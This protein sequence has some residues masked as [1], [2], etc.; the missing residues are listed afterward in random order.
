ML[1]VSSTTIVTGSAPER[2]IGFP[3]TGSTL[4]AVL[5]FK[6]SRGEAPARL[7][8]S[9]DARCL[10]PTTDKRIP[11]WRRS[12]AIRRK[13]PRQGV[14]RMWLQDGGE[15]APVMQCITISH[16]FCA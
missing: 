7:L 16:G 12:S 1:C 13:E 14:G 3:G 6:R 8:V 4:A 11:G 15:G 5:P 9:F 2:L 10:A